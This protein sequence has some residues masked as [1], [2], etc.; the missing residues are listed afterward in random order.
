MKKFLLLLIFVAALPR[1]LLLDTVPAG[2]NFEEIDFLLNAK[3]IYTAW[4]DISGQW[5][6]LSLS[7]PPADEPRNELLPLIIAPLIG[8]LPFSLFNSRLPFALIGVFN[9]VLIYLLGRK[10]FSEK[11][12]RIAGFVAAFNPWLIFSSRLGFDVPTSATFYL[13]ALVLLYY[14]RGWT[15]VLAFVPLF[16]AFYTYIGAKVIFLPFTLASVWLAWRENGRKFTRPYLL[17]IVMSILT[18]FLFV[19]RLGNLPAHS[20]STN[21][22]SPAHADVAALVDSQRRQNLSVPPPI[23]ILN[24][25]YVNKFTLYAKEILNRTLGVVSPSVLFIR[26]DPYAPYFLWDHGLFYYS[27]ALFLLIGFIILVRKYPKRA[28]FFGL[29]FPISILLSLLSGT[30]LSYV[31]RS[32]LFFVLLILIIAL[33][34]DRL[35]LTVINHQKLVV[36]FLSFIYLFQF[37]NLAQDYFL[38]NPFYHESQ[39]QLTSRLLSRYLIEEVKTGRKVVV[40]GADP[41]GL[42]RQYILYSGIFNNLSDQKVGSQIAQAFKNKNYTWGNVT[43]TADCEQASLSGKITL[44]QRH[45]KPCEKV[46]EFSEVKPIK[47]ARI[48]DSGGDFKIFFGNI[49]SNFGL[50]KYIREINFS[51]LQIER[52]SLEKYCQTFFESS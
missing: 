19:L 35:I 16:L 17:V 10:L 28:L 11:V 36:L 37:G 18:L 49:C 24:T 21:F 26:G 44:I 38:R 14:L 9:V 50:P 3:T 15:I 20:R 29:L 22:F 39:F 25:V 46:D 43:F 42:F 30:A 34:I 41:N 23:N 6:P 4:T 33:G 40:I 2:I 7:T 48:S 12:G 52:L 27:D 51:D 5:N 31:Y 8:P 45:D 47:L 32:Y 13:F 1:L